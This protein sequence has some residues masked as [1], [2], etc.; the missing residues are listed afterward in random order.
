MLFELLYTIIA[1]VTIITLLSII[2]A[3][4]SFFIS[5]RPILSQFVSL[6]AFGNLFKK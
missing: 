5:D 3:G 4:F 1:N 6:R 2:A